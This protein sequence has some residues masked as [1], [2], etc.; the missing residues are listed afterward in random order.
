M[1]KQQ[2]Q[3]DARRDIAEF[4]EGRQLCGLVL[5]CR[6]RDE[7]EDAG[8]VRGVAEKIQG[9]LAAWR[10]E[11]SIAAYFQ[12]ST[13]LGKTIRVIGRVYVGSDEY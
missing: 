11:E 7:Q 3:R 13:K 4:I 8:R 9:D 1:T 2:E 10:P 6:L 5:A 12:L